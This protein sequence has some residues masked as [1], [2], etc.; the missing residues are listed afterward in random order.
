[1]LSYGK[2]G[3][4]MSFDVSRVQRQ[5]LGHGQRL[6]VVVP[7]PSAAVAFAPLLVARASKAQERRWLSSALTGFG[8]L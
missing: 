6:A 3:C 2:P 4:G 7:S 5:E 8:A 1:M